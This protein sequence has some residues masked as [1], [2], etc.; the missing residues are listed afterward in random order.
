MYKREETERI[1]KKEGDT[2]NRK[3]VINMRNDE[4]ELRTCLLSR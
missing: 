1:E 4:Y 2:G 3:L